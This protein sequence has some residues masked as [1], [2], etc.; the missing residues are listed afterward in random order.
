MRPAILCGLLTAFAYKCGG[1]SP[2]TGFDCSGLVKHVFQKAWGVA[3]PR[4]T[5]EQKQVGRSVK[6]KELEA[7]DLVFYNTRNKPYSH[8]GIYVGDGRFI[9][10][11]R[12]G[13]RVESSHNRYWKA[14][15]NGARRVDP[16]VI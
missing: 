14:R 1:D 8:V 16:P 13:A 9:H 11:P 4:R 5:Q 2:E 10:A 15:F 7:G 6:L 3:L 12:T